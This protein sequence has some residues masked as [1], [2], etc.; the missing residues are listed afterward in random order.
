MLLVIAQRLLRKGC[1]KCGQN[2]PR[3]ADCDCHQGYKGRTGIYQFLQPHFVRDQWQYSLDYAELRQ[4]AQE[5]IRLNITDQAEVDRVLGR[6]M[7]KQP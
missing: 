3:F 6:A 1:S 5:K 2:P 4:A 7:E